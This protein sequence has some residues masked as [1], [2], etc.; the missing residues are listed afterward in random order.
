[1][2]FLGVW[3]LT[4]DFQVA[5]TFRASQLPRLSDDWSAD[6]IYELQKS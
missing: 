3:I 4:F 2:A 1:M 5:R 6:L